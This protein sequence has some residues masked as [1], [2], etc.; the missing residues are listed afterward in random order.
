MVICFRPRQAK[1][2]SWRT[3]RVECAGLK[4]RE[5][6]WLGAKEM[7]AS[8]LK[9]K[10]FPRSSMEAGLCRNCPRVVSCFSYK[11]VPSREARGKSPSCLDDS[12]M[13]SL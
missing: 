4:E 6:D 1:S 10:S 13:G 11:S 3:F 5:L 2:S 9:R 8:N 7:V 12:S